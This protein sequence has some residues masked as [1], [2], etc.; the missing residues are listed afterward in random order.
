MAFYNKHL[1]LPC[2]QCLHCRLAK[3]RD[4][5]IR[6]VHEAQMHQ[7]NCFVSLTYSDDFLPSDNSIN[8]KHWQNFA[9]RLRKIKGPF[10]FLHCG[11]YGDENKRPHYHACLFG[12]D[13]A[14]DR[15]VYS[16]ENGHILWTSIQLENIWGVGF[17]TIGPLNFDTA[18]YCASYITKKVRPPKIHDKNKNQKRIDYEQHSLSLVA[19]AYQ[20]VDPN[21]GEITTVKPEY[22]TM[23]R[24]PGLGSKWFDKYLTDVYPE[25]EVVINGKTFRPPKYYDQLL[26]KKNPMLM[27]KLKLQ[28]RKKSNEH[29][30]EQTY[31][32][33]KV[34]DTVLKAK[35]AI[36]KRKL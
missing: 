24:R 25:D 12:L 16:Q 6:C 13:F 3:T 2:G 26:E 29:P 31:K 22:A 20:R 4:W 34:Q 5:A 11:E 27:E 14:E 35:I 17:A 23:S 15:V 21:T 18:A 32:R 9:K 36:K 1:E 19:K 10:R 8:V 33:R 30:E 28:R 7:K